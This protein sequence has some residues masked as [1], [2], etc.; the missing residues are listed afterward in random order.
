MGWSSGASTHGTWKRVRYLECLVRRDAQ[1]EMM[2]G[3]DW[4]VGVLNLSM[5]TDEPKQ[6]Y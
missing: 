3:D 1:A 5:G 6:D 4:V 2:V